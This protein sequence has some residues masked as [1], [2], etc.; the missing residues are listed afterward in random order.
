MSLI[1][2]LLSAAII[3]A[4][5]DT[6][7]HHAPIGE[8][9]VTGT[10]EAVS[11]N[12]IPYTVS[13]ISEQQLEAS[14]DT[15]ILSIISGQ[16][17]SL[18]VT[19]R[20]I[21]GFGVS[22]GGS[23]HIKMRGVGSDRAS[24]VLMMV[25]GQPQFAGI[26]S[27]QIADFYSK[28]YV[29][30]VEVL[31]GPGSVLY[32][33][34]AMAGVINVITRRPKHHGSR[35]SISVRGGSFN[36]WQ[37]SAT[38]TLNFN[39]FSSLISGG[40]N[41]TDGSVKGFSFNQAYG[42]GKLGYRFSSHWQGTADYTIM[43]FKGSDP[44]YPRT[45]DE[46]S[47]DIYHQNITRGE[48]S[49]S[50][51][52]SYGTT[53]NGSIRA[54]YSYGNHFIDDPRH[55]HSTDDRFGITAFQNINP[56]KQASWTIGFDFDRYSGRI[57]VSG[58]RPHTPGSLST[59]ERKYILEYS[60][61]ITAAQGFFNNI[62]TVNAGVR[63]A[64]SQNFHSQWVPQAGFAINPTSDFAIKASMAKGYRNPSFR[65]LYLYRMANPDLQPEQS[66]NY[67]VSVDK[68]FGPWLSASL[69]GY[70]IRGSQM[71]QQ[72]SAKNIN[73]GKF[74]NKGVEVSLLSHPVSTLML[75]ASYSYLHSSIDLLTAAPRHQ[76]YIGADWNPIEQLKISADLKGVGRML[77]DK[78]MPQQSYATVDLNTSYA[79]N[80]NISIDLSL[81]NI[82]CA[83]YTIVPGY[84]MP[85][86][87]AM[88][89]LKVNF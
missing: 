23:G 19:E 69:T 85:G 43:N 14:P 54:Y 49:L 25:D 53:T 88:G 71:I 17:P 89:G 21:A 80:R 13:V 63:L 84:Q 66:I 55:F 16:V 46:Q 45:I 79:I 33:S 37:A 32:G 73:T 70:Y 20:G 47:T 75:R 68:S 35:T 52:N 74:Y 67:E 50:V 40:Y 22:T 10:N 48:A 77:A 87:T 18:F 15:K 29:E 65:E 56:W 51:T 3:T 24:S 34:N 11:K 62:V 83:S 58:G 41:H 44:L 61:Y 31:R 36:T 72:V 30:R 12:L 2:P 82:T 57:P 64:M 5:T 39:Q 60:P 9:V 1:T 26:Y 81:E 38:N 78:D 8:V 28:E 7:I 59:L 27:H 4:P 76:Y 86:I 42:Y 6:V